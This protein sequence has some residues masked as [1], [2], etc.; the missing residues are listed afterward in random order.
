MTLCF[1]RWVAQ[2]H[3]VFKIKYNEYHSTKLNE[4]PIDDKIYDFKS[5]Y[6]LNLIF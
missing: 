4:T 3:V 5:Y 1:W 6:V 2:E